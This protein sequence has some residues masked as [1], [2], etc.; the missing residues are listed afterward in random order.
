MS[1]RSRI[2]SV[3]T[4][5]FL[6]V[7]PCVGIAE[8]AYKYAITT[9]YRS[10]GGSNEAVK[11]NFLITP[12]GVACIPEHYYIDDL[13]RILPPGGEFKYSITIGQLIRDYGNKIL[14]LETDIEKLKS[15]NQNLKLQIGSKA[16]ANLVEEALSKNLAKI[17]EIPIIIADNPSV[18]SALSEKI[19]EK[20]LADPK[21]RIK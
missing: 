4:V 13:V 14:T 16:S 18:L 5:C 11:G 10:V 21:F 8:D 7:F 9:C 19:M 20:L 1:F 6:Y 15:E 2:A 3:V 12:I 17:D